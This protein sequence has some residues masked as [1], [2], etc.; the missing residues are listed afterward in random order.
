MWKEYPLNR[1][2]ARTSRSNKKQPAFDPSELTDLIFTPA[3]GSGVGSHLVGTMRDFPAPGAEAKRIADMT[4]VDDLVMPTVVTSKES[5]VDD[6]T[7]HRAEV[8]TVD[9]SALSTVDDLVMPTVVTSKESTV[10]D[11]TVHGAGWLQ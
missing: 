2:M 10:D 7:V 1:N 4:T 8:A 3:V 9:M 5:T 6:R 11:R